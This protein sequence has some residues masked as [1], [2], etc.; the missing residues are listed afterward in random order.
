M[1]GKTT[2]IK[3]VGIHLILGRTL[4]VCFARRATLPDTGVTAVIRGE[5]SVESGKSYYFAEMTAI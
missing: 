5:N 3:L 1:A 4:G 2:F